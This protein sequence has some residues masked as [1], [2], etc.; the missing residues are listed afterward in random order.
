MFCL[1][2]H[3]T[4]KSDLGCG[5]GNFAAHSDKPSGTCEGKPKCKIFSSNAYLKRLLYC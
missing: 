1:I 4:R 5:D 2:I 3:L